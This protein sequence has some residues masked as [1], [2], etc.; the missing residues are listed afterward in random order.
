MSET[1]EEAQMKHKN[2]GWYRKI[3]DDT[4]ISHM[5]Q[6]NLSLRWYRKI[7][8]ETQISQM[9]QKIYMC[10]K[11]IS[12]RWYRKFADETQ[13]SQMIQKFHICYKR[14]SLSDG[15]EKSQMKHKIRR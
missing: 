8:D 5:L 13:N 7:A 4:E 12:L 15:T 9:I 14:I 11:R 6:A 3:A 10:Y 1:T 2:P